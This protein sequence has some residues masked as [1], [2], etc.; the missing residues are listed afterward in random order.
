M[1]VTYDAKKLE[2]IHIPI[3]LYDKNFWDDLINLDKFLEMGLISEE[4]LD[5]FHYFSNAKEGIDYLRPKL[6]Y[7]IK[8]LSNILERK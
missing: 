8:N 2:K 6:K 4:D 5:I 7:N 1:K 3:L